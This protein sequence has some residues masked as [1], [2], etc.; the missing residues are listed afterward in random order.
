MYLVYISKFSVTS[1]KAHEY[2][3]GTSAIFPVSG[4]LRESVRRLFLTELLTS[5]RIPYEE[6]LHKLDTSFCTDGK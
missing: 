1:N 5:V 3:F 2:P 4:Q 6:Y